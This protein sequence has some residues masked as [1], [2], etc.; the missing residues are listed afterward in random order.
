MKPQDN[1]L[2]TVD[3]WTDIERDLGGGQGGELKKEAL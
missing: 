1:L 3:N 2:K